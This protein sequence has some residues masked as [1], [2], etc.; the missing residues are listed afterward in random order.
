LALDMLIEPYL[1]ELS[2]N[3]RVNILVYLASTMAPAWIPVMFQHW[4][5]R[6][7]TSSAATG[8]RD[9]DEFGRRWGYFRPCSFHTP[10]SFSQGQRSLA[11]GAVCPQAAAMNSEKQERAMSGE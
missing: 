11:N 5:P 4:T 2:N 1:N 3:E 9:F 10:I 6:W 8:E 7:R